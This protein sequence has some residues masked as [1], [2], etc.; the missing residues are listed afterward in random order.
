MHTA[1]TKII[2][3]ACRIFV[4]NPEGVRPFRR[5]V[6]RRVVSVKIDL[7]IILCAG[8]DWILLA[9]DWVQF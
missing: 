7:V 4:K 6:F 3:N 1:L 9:Q 8:L 2:I 5:P